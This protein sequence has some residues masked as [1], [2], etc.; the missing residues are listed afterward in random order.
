MTSKVHYK[1]RN[2]NAECDALSR[3]K[4]GQGIKQKV[5]DAILDNHKH[6]NSMVG[7]VCLSE[8]GISEAHG[9]TLPEIICQSQQMDN[10]HFSDRH[11]EITIRMMKT[12]TQYVATCRRYIKR[13]N[14]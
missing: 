8:N 10:S 2:S 11:E 14:I 6:I 1:S 3:I 7:T 9:A 12:A 5:V 13:K 4:L